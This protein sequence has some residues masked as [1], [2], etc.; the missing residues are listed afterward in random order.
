MMEIAGKKIISIQLPY[1]LIVKL[2]C[3]SQAPA[4]FAIIGLSLLMAF[5]EK[6]RGAVTRSHKIASGLAKD[7]LVLPTKT[8]LHW[9]TFKSKIPTV[10]VP[11]DSSMRER[12]D[13]YMGYER[14]RVKFDEDFWQ[15][16][17][18]ND[19][20]AGGSSNEPDIMLSVLA[21]K[22]RRKKEGV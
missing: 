18:K 21:E 17:Q 7:F 4:S 12:L 14:H 16:R 10:S 19:T 22:A 5:S 11:D 3:F 13:G 1:F 8:F 2:T 15:R 20:R 9:Q 6:L